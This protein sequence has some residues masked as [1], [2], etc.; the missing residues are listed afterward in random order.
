MIVSEVPRMKTGDGDLA[1]NWA[2]HESCYIGVDIVPFTH[3]VRSGVG[4]C[5]YQ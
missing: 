4:V 1:G 2:S 5:V 3:K